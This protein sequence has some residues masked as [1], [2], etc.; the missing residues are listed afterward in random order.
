MKKLIPLLIIILCACER[1]LT[2]HRDDIPDRLQVNAQLVAGDTL[3]YVHL[4]VSKAR[5]ISTVTDGAVR[6]FVN[7]KHVA[8]GKAL[9]YESFPG[10]YPVPFGLGEHPLNMRQRSFSFR[11][12]FKPGDLVRIEA[13]ANGG[14][15][16]ASAEASVPQ[17]PEIA[18]KEI[19]LQ[20]LEGDP[21]MRIRLRGKDDGGE[22][23]YYRI[24]DACLDGLEHLEMDPGRDPV[25]ND[26]AYSD[27]LDLVGMSS[28]MFMLYSDKRFDGGDYEVSFYLFGTHM[29][30]ELV[31]SLLSISETE[32]DYLKAM[33]LYD[34]IG[35]DTVFTEPASF[36]DNVEG[37]VGL[38]SI[39]AR[40]RI[41]LQVQN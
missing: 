37:G 35:G 13:E 40:T 4:A 28:N 38:V 5:T 33:E 29:G 25:L 23:N 14:Q 1:D 22:R 20:E 41:V 27:E 21:A 15:F 8:D 10:G 26:G 36:P 17:A 34:I 16:S 31:L 24:A 12:D 11:A 2:W 3:H 39:A 32:Y 18:L 6:I 19:S 7:G 9:D 30:R